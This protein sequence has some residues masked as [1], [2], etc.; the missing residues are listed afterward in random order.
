MRDGEQA[1]LDGSC[2]SVAAAAAPAV[3][4]HSSLESRGSGDVQMLAVQKG[5]PFAPNDAISRR[6]PCRPCRDTC[7]NCRL[8]DAEVSTYHCA[9]KCE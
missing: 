6:K 9:V 4:T 7:Y 2:K 5:A 8:R 1:M 3:T